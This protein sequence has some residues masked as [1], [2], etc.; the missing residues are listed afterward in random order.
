MTSRVLVALRIAAPPERV[1]EAFTTEIGDWWQPNRLFQPTDRA[2]G[3]LSMEAGPGG[4][5]L[6]TGEDG[7]V[8]EIGRIVT[9][10]PPGL[11][12]LLWRPTSFSAGQDTEVR[13]HFEPVEDATRVVVEHHGWDGIPRAHAARHGFPLFAFQQRLAEWWQDLLDSLD[14]QCTA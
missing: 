12:A 7:A 10:D 11:L 1:F 2:T 13:V 14:E 8:D 6:E 9:W 3:R 5:L 4:R